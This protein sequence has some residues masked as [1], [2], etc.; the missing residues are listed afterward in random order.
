MDREKV[1]T[2]VAKVRGDAAVDEVGA[3]FFKRRAGRSFRPKRSSCSSLFPGVVIS[4]KV[5]GIACEVRDVSLA[6]AGLRCRSKVEPGSKILFELFA[7]DLPLFS[8][9]CSVEWAES[10]GVFTDFGVAH[11]DLFDI[12][13]LQSKTSRQSA[14]KAIKENHR[15]FYDD[16]PVSYRLLSSELLH[17]L[18]SLRV[19]A[20]A[21]EKPGTAVSDETRR[22]STTRL[23]QEA[24]PEFADIWYRFNDIVLSVERDEPSFRAMKWHTENV[25]RPHFMGAPVWERSWTKPL[26][27][28]GDYRIMLYAYDSHEFVRTDTLFDSVVHGYLAHTLGACIRGRMDLTLDHIRAR[29]AEC[30][31][32]PSEPIEM[33]NLGCGA[34]RE[35]PLLLADHDLVSEK[36]INITLIEQDVEALQ[37]AIE[38]SYGTTTRFDG[39]VDVRGLNVS[40]KDVLRAGKLADELGPQDVI[41]SLGLID[42]FPLS[43]GKKMAKDLYQRLK[44]GGV[45]TWC[46]VATTRETCYWPLEFLTDWTLYYRNESEMRDMFDLEGA[47]VTLELEASNQIWVINAKKP[48]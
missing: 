38:W 4:A 23:L 27:Y 39:R 20:D 33:M 14:R 30:E 9:D 46:N 16:L 34:A 26:G 45:L 5:A 35:I 31:G 40:F 3:H 2:Q 36:H 43:L 42:Y 41:Y 6:G 8:S 37:H 15:T 29:V 17:H 19:K 48:F 21:L 12:G 44:P 22:S 47:E 32:T 18:A 7:D 11:D 25:L 28:P 13:R 24:G 10:D 1:R